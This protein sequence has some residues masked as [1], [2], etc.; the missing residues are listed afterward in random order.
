EGLEDINL[1]FSK[2]VKGT[3]NSIAQIES[4]LAL[5]QAQTRN[6]DEATTA[7][8]QVLAD[9]RAQQEEK[10]AT[11]TAHLHS[12]VSETQATLRTLISNLD[13]KASKVGNDLRVLNDRERETTKKRLEHER[14]QGEAIRSLEETTHHQAKAFE[15]HQME[16]VKELEGVHLQHGQMASRVGD[17]EIQV[18]QLEALTKD[19]GEQLTTLHGESVSLGA[20]LNGLRDR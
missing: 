17:T 16:V 4:A 11:E 12:C 20:R 18:T 19:H 6:Q 9:S 15:A 7:L 3:K 2:H 5:L 10:I 13:A 8:Q 14:R 1:A